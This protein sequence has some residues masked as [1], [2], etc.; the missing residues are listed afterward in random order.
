MMDRLEKAMTTI[1]LEERRFREMFGVSPAV[2]LV[3]WNMMCDADLLPEKGELKHWLWTLCFLKVYAKQAPLCA[4]CGAADPKTINN[5]VWAFI[6]AFIIL[7]GE[8]VSIK[9]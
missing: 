1:A 2:A 7:E 3:A 4:L 5:W 6:Q 8:G 9:S